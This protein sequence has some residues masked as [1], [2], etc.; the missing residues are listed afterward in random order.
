LGALA[1]L[2]HDLSV[3]AIGGQV[4]AEGNQLFSNNGLWAV[5]DQLE[6]E[7]DALGV[8]ESSLQLVFLTQ[9]I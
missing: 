7:R 1:F 2:S 6:A 5:D 9:M 8:G 3:K 4:D